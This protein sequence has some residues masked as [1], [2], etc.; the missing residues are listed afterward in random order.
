MSAKVTTL[1]ELEQ[2]VSTLAKLLAPGMVVGLSGP[3]GVGK[4]ELVRALVRLWGC[5][6]QVVSPTF[7]LESIYHL[8]QRQCVVHH[9]D[10]YRLKGAEVPED[11]QECS[12]DPTAITLVEWPEYVDGLADLLDC[13]IV[14][15]FET[16]GADEGDETRSIQVYFREN[17]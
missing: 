2:F 4:T 11:L 8:S 9:W 6:E 1:G 16:L 5:A 12:A 13:K 15:A 14:L 10:L 7:V 3:L 17:E